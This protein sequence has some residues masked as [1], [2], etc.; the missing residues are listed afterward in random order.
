MSP[1]ISSIADYSALRENAQQAASSP[2]PQWT[3]PQTPSSS[4]NTSPRDNPVVFASPLGVDAER[5]N[6]SRG[7]NAVAIDSPMPQQIIGARAR[8]IDMEVSPDMLMTNDELRQFA[9]G[10]RLVPPVPRLIAA[11]PTRAVR[12]LQSAFDQSSETNTVALRLS[13]SSSS[14]SPRNVQYMN[15]RSEG[16]S[17]V[18]DVGRTPKAVA[19][20]LVSDIS[21][22]AVPG[23]TAYVGDQYGRAPQPI[24]QEL[25]LQVAPA[26]LRPLLQSWP[27]VA[28]DVRYAA[29]RPPALVVSQQQWQQQ[30]Q[31]QSAGNRADHVMTATQTFLRN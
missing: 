6:A 15:A 28:T 14:T 16:N 30:Q 13:S 9:A 18:G 10:L 19:T 5:Y 21:E 3:Q 23:V 11:I 17:I 24:M 7:G 20:V 26:S 25:P 4:T 27:P 2:L 31:R 1:P 12:N 22:W 29:F 8:N